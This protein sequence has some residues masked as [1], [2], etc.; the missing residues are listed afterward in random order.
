MSKRSFARASFDFF[1]G[2]TALPLAVK[3]LPA[4]ADDES[5]AAQETFQ[6]LLI[7]W[8]EGQRSLKVTNELP[9]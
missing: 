5:Q 8:F 2:E 6:K 1:N 7:E 3:E 4:T 9:L